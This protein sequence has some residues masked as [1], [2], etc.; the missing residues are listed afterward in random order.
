MKSIYIKLLSVRLKSVSHPHIHNRVHKMRPWSKPNTVG[1]S[2]SVLELELVCS[3]EKY[4]WSSRTN[5]R[6]TGVQRCSAETSQQEPESCPQLSRCLSNLPWSSW[7]LLINTYLCA[8]KHI[9]YENTSLVI[10][11]K[12]MDTN[13]YQVGK[14]LMFFSFNIY[15]LYWISI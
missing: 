2:S 7:H 6:V 15:V 3:R 11:E 10:S 1:K 12:T 14:L 5:E 9:G 8:N 4:W 13:I